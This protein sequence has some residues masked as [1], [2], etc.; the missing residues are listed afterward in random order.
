MLERGKLKG[1]GH[2]IQLII[3]QP[4]QKGTGQGH[5]INGREGKIHIISS[6]GRLDK[7]G[8]KGSVVGHKDGVFPHKI[9]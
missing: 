2:R 3:F 9:S 6:G 8:V 5:R 1:I 7:R 4:M